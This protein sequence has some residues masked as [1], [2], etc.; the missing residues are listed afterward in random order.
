MDTPL[1]SSTPELGR[2]GVERAGARPRSL[3][4]ALGDAWHEVRGL[5]RDHAALAV[6]EAQHAG[7]R[8][9]MLVGLALAVGVL[10]VTAWL[11]LITAFAVWLLGEG[12]SWPAVLVVAALLNVL[13]AGILLW[14]AKSRVAEMPFPATLR[15]LSED[16]DELTE[17]G[18]N[19]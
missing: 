8:F 15:Q 3:V 6:L 10:A 9:A 11:T 14:V 13:I 4:G 2:P 1:D 19:A 7:I 12:M 17:R 16:K 5:V 18:D